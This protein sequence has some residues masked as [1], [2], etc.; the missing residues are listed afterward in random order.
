M[1]RILKITAITTVLTVLFSLPVYASMGGFNTTPIFPANQV[2][3]TNSFYDF[4]APPGTTQQI[5]VRINST[6]TDTDIS[7]E[8]S[9]TTATTNRNRI[10]DYS[11]MEPD[12]PNPNAFSN[13]ASFVDADIIASGGI[14]TLSPGEVRDVT[15]NIAIPP[16]H[17]DGMILGAVHVLQILTAE[18]LSQ[19]GMFA[20]RMAQVLPVRIRGYNTS[21]PVAFELGHVEAELYRGRG[22]IIAEII[23][24]NHR[25]TLG[26]EMEA[27][28]YPVNSDEPVFHLSGLM[29]DFAPGSIFPLYITDHAGF[30]FVAGD[31]IAAI[32]LVH[33]NV[34]F[35][36]A[37]A[38][39]IPET[40]A[41]EVA[42]GAVNLQQQV[43]PP[44]SVSAESFNANVTDINMLII[45]AIAVPTVLL[46]AVLVLQIIK[47]KKA[48]AV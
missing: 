38:F 4:H 46:G 48:K 44:G 10:I 9:L 8:L 36:M 26:T 18:D 24:P 6:R 12:L 7:M 41:E 1:L 2:A 20:N 28:I 30:G 25:M 37:Q 27:R 5:I 34:T 11:T 23:H 47:I 33:N 16:E 3:E 13:I 22:T 17:F 40:V 14:L 19:S 31:Y 32:T 21:L 42:M 29:V 45:V 35:D 15:V 39:T 43:A